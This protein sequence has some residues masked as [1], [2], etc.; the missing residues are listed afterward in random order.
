[1]SAPKILFL[2]TRAEEK[3]ILLC[4]VVE[5]FFDEGRK[6][7]V[8][9]DSTMAAQMIDNLLWTFSQGSF[10]PHRVVSLP[11]PQ[12]IVEPVVITIGELPLQGFDILVV[13]ERV[14]LETMKE[15]ALAV[16]FVLKDDAEKRQES[17][18]LWQAAKEEGFQ[19][20]HLSSAEK[21]ADL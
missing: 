10:V 17:R 3:R 9:V 14:N 12:P 21:L 7:Q 2:E 13:D 8:L 20:Q 16:H 11:L 1:M 19:L 6:I 4:R 18:Q 5:H 15:Y